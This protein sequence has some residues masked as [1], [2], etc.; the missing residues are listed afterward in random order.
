LQFRSN[1]VLALGLII[2]AGCHFDS[3]NPPSSSTQQAAAG[4][5]GTA[6][7]SWEMP[8]R[9]TSGGPLTD[10]AGYTILYGPSPQAMNQ[11]V[12]I[13]DVGT[14]SYTVSGLAA[15]TWYFAVLSYTASGADSALSNLVS[16][17]VH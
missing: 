14:T 7:L 4:G 11:F 13:T 15:G 1:I 3:D 6:A 5:P 8:T 2:L 16:T 17:T 9:N 10:L 12:Q